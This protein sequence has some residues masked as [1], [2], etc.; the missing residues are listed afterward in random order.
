[1]I[2]ILTC[3][4]HSAE[5]LVR[6][7]LQE[8]NIPDWMT[9]PVHKGKEH[10][11]AILERFPE[12]YHTLLAFNALLDY[13]DRT[14]SYAIIVAYDDRSFYWSDIHSNAPQDRFQADTLLKQFA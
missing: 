12:P 14:S 13:L 9:Y 6:T 1:M 10:C 3:E 2:L 11:K 8:A 7:A 4:C 5:P